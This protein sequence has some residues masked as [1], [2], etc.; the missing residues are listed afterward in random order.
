M[1]CS[2]FLIIILST[3]FLITCSKKESSKTL[4]DNN[5]IEL[6]LFDQNKLKNSLELSSNTHLNHFTNFKIVYFDSQNQTL[7]LELDNQPNVYFFTKCMIDS[8]MEFNLLG[9]TKP[10]LVYYGKFTFISPNYGNFAFLAFNYHEESKNVYQNYFNDYLSLDDVSSLDFA[11]CE[12]FIDN[13]FNALLVS[14]SEGTGNYLDYRIYG[15]DQKTFSLLSEPTA[16]LENGLFAIDSN[17]IYLMEGMNTTKL[18]Y[19]NHKILSE[20]LNFTPIF[21]EKNNDRVLE[22]KIE[23]DGKITYPKFIVMNS[24]A[25]LHLSLKNSTNN[26]G[27]DIDFNFDHSFWDRN[28]NTLIPK[29]SGVT[30]INLENSDKIILG[31][32]RVIV[33]QNIKQ[34][35]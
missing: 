2:L 21:N 17:A 1:R 12:K 14:Y 29:E 4:T 32:V 19:Q 25:S 34:P 13:K 35:V 16:P 27:N 10:E 5:L 18:I 8:V 7:Y 9:S 23:N 26:A 31:R 28:F 30:N 11:L 22:I 6:N 20:S 3:I 24:D 33:R 15:L